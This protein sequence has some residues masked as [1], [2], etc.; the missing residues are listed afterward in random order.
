MFFFSIEKMYV[1]FPPYLARHAQMYVFFSMKKTYFPP[2]G[3]KIDV[4]R[5]TIT[6]A[7]QTYVFFSENV[8]AKSFL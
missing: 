7:M 6:V 3:W 8:F 1:F 2:H 5:K 4:H